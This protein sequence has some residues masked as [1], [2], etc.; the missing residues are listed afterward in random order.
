V[1][2]IGE[3]HGPKGELMEYFRTFAE[4]FNTCTLPHDKYYDLDAWEKAEA[5]AAA[6]RPGGASASSA[7]AGIN[8]LADEA[9]R[10]KEAAEA[11]RQRELQRT[12]LY[13]AAMDKEKMAAMQRQEELRRKM[14]Y[15]FKAG[16][17]REAERLQRLLEPQEK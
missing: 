13:I 17:V 5:V 4:D 7:A 12:A 8:V 10:R 1:R 9:A 15:A 11:A 2:G 16:D 14:Q 6:A 3:W